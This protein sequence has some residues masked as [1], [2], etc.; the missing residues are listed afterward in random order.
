ME[1]KEQVL[2]ALQSIQEPYL[3]KSLVQVGGIRDVV[4]KDSIVGM[5]V[6]LTQLD[7]AEKDQNDGQIRAALAGKVSAVHIRFREMTPYEREK[8][9]GEQGHESKAKQAEPVRGHGENLESDI[10]SPDSGVSFIAIA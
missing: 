3:H 10:L 1:T 2:E 6:A 7:K 9:D 4:V 5:T 8:I